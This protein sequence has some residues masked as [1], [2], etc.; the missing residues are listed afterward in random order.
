MT[1][2]SNSFQPTAPVILMCQS[3]TEPMY[4][5]VNCP[6]C[7]EQVLSWMGEQWFSRTTYG[8]TSCH[9]C[10]KPIALLRGD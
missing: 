4:L 1:E 7:G 3:E 6:H 10:D 8:M 2:L 5:E 9:A